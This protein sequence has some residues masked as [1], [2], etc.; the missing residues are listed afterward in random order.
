MI[1]LHALKIDVVATLG[2]RYWRRFALSINTQIT[3]KLTKLMA[4]VI[5]LFCQKEVWRKYL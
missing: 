1:K 3:K 5:R 2:K 4:I